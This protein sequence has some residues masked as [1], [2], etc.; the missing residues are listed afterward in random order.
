MLFFLPSMLPL[1]LIRF[2]GFVWSRMNARNSWGAISGCRRAGSQKRSERAASSTSPSP[3]W[4]DDEAGEARGPPSLF[5]PVLL[6]LLLYGER[7][8]SV[9]SSDRPSSGS[10]MLRSPGWCAAVDDADLEVDAARGGERER[11]GRDGDPGGL[12]RP[13]YFV[14]E[15][16]RSGSIPSEGCEMDLRRRERRVSSSA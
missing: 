2:S 4:D 16:G 5:L 15:G 8:D 1:L 3:S 14:G 9:M 6:L 11:P 10:R 13:L 7:R 12:G